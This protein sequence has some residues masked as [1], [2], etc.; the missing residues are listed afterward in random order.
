MDALEDP[1]PCLDSQEFVCLTERIRCCKELLRAIYLGKR[2]SLKHNTYFC[3]SKQN[4]KQL[5][6]AY[7]ASFD[8]IP[9]SLESS[10]KTEIL[11][12]VLEFANNFVELDPRKEEFSV[13]SYA[14][15]VLLP[16]CTTWLT[17]ELENYPLI[18]PNNS[19]KQ[20]N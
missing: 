14:Y 10:Q 16:E 9:Y 17:I 12:I 11:D 20:T 2:F 8:S 6:I 1:K 19:F 15:D 7:L 4:R 18:F 13:P 5:K 3:N